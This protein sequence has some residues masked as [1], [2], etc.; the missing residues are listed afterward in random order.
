MKSMRGFGYLAL[1]L[2]LVSA[3]GAEEFG[4]GPGDSGGA[5]SDVVVDKDQNSPSQGDAPVVGGDA[6]VSGDATE[7]VEFCAKQKD[8]DDEVWCTDD[9]CTIEGVC[10][11]QLSDDMCLIDGECLVDGAENPKNVCEKCRPDATRER[12]STRHLEPCDDDDPCTVESFCNKD[13][14]EGIPAES[15]CG[16]GIVETGE[17]C[18]GDCPETCDDT[19]SCAEVSLIGSAETCDAICDVLPVSACMSGDGC[20]PPHCPLA[21]DD[22]CTGMC[23]NGAL[24][25]GELCDGDCPQSCDD[26]DVCTTDTLLGNASTCDAQCKSAPITVCNTGDGCC[27]EGC[28]SE[29]DGDCPCSLV[30]DLECADYTEK[31]YYATFSVSVD[32]PHGYMSYNYP[33]NE[34]LGTSYCMKQ[35]GTNPVYVTEG[36]IHA[37]FEK[38][39]CVWPEG[40]PD[41]K[42]ET[43]KCFDCTPQCSD[44]TTDECLTGDGCCPDGC[45]GATDGDCPG[46]CGDGVVDPG[47]TCDPGLEG[48]CPTS[49]DDGN[50]CATKTLVGAAATCDA[51]CE[52]TLKTECV[53]GDDC[54]PIGCDVSTDSDCNCTIEIDVKCADD[55]T[56]EYFATYAVSVD[57]PDGHLYYTASPNGVLLPNWC[58]S[59]TGFLPVYEPQFCV[60]ATYETGDCVL[61]EGAGPKACEATECFDCAPSC[62]VVGGMN[63]GDDYDDTWTNEEK[64]I[65]WVY[66]PTEA[67]VIHRVEVFTGQVAAASRI[68]LWSHDVS[69]DQPDVALAGGDF[70]TVVPNGWQGATLETPVAMTAGTSYWIVWEMPDNS[71]TS[72]TATGDMVTY[73]AS[74]AAGAAWTGPWSEED[75]FRL[76]NCAP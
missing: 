44:T 73:K 29:K 54:C 19:D 40:T 75:K 33:P 56:L 23:G 52:T 17:R 72:R 5:T 15:C 27:P 61:P 37:T 67:M 50:P 48:S 63:T 51:H 57:E 9:L 6:P 30:I 70:T 1:V 47:E 11:H 46:E 7:A 65:A 41:L 25:D 53:A 38:G 43:T 16:N 34:E 74:D 76:Y 24:D 69:G 32:A 8:C 22:D 58:L 49:C 68:G 55:E 36:C 21:E 64:W 26:M 31:G 71:Q 10:L 42:C 28:T 62:T 39:T 60:K 4:T 14:C 20:C 45:N 59:D 66:T 18:D 3:C 35:S 12:W 2:W 13:I